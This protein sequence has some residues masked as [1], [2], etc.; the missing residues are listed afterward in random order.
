[1]IHFYVSVVGYMIHAPVLE[2]CFEIV[3]GMINGDELHFGLVYNIFNIILTAIGYFSYYFFYR[4]TYSYTFVFRPTSFQCVN[5]MQQIITI[6]VC[7]FQSCFIGC[8]SYL[9][10]TGQIIVYSLQT[11]LV[12]P[13]IYSL[14]LKFSFVNLFPVSYTHLTLPT[15]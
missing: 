10:V 7:Y 6:Y 13:A 15:M 12:I 14:F 9:S 8:L 11:I 1:M 5:G 2:I 3:G 4:I